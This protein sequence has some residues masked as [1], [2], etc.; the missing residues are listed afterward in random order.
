M[1]CILVPVANGWKS[2]CLHWVHS[3]VGHTSQKQSRAYL[4]VTRGQDPS[5][6][7]QGSCLP[8]TPGL[9]RRWAQVP[10]ATSAEL[11]KGWTMRLL[12]ASLLHDARACDNAER[13]HTT[14]G[15]ALDP[16]RWGKGVP[17][18]VVYSLTKLTALGVAPQKGPQCSAPWQ[19]LEWWQ[20]LSSLGKS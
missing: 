10:R 20:K 6:P 4:I 17:R 2:R 11:L 18:R 9:T 7:R 5:N 14:K 1:V 3:W 16:L 8:R 19:R 13:E 12:N 15:A